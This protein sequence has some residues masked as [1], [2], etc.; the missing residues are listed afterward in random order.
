MRARRAPRIILHF[1]E[2]MAKIISMKQAP[3]SA[4]L[5]EDNV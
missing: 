3:L 5:L 1:T 2:A 4:L